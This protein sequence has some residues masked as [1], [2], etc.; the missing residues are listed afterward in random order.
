VN[1]EVVSDTTLK[2]PV[3]EHVVKVGKSKFYRIS[4]V[5]ESGSVD[6]EGR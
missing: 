2:L 5:G 1:D 6:A 4:I 3:G